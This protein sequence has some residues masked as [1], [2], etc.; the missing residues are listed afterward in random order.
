LSRRQKLLP[1]SGAVV[2]GIIPQLPRLLF[3]QIKMKTMQEMLK[4]RRQ[5]NC[6]YRQKENAAE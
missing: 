5:E 6:K 3:A 1:T 4:R 2:N